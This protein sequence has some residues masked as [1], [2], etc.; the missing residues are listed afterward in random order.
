MDLS[1]YV[2]DLSQIHECQCVDSMM[3]ILNTE[4]FLV[5]DYRSCRT[6]NSE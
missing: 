6:S 1:K 3:S 2:V 5:L 4:A